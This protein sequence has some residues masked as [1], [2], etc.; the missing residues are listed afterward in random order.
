VTDSASPDL[1]GAGVRL[2]AYTDEDLAL[3]LALESDAAVMRSLGGPVGR[4]EAVRIHQ[5]RL[6]RMARGDLFFTIVPAGSSSPVGI[7]ALFATEWEGTTVYEAGLMFLPTFQRRGV[8]AQALRIL[9]D[10]ARTE[11]NL[12]E[13]HGF[14]AVTSEA[15]NTMAGR[16][17]FTL[18]GEC[19]LDY[20]SR[21]IRCNHWVLDLT[22]R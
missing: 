14:T 22:P 8:G 7:A 13:L 15:G 19:D 4:D 2:V 11:K 16:F 10:K 17:G 6:E 5:R 20:E 21:P 3:T 12:P 9:I 18:V 1:G